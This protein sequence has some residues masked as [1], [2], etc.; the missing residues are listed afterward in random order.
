M[1]GMDWD[2]HGDEPGRW[3]CFSGAGS[4]EG[5]VAWVRVVWQ[6]VVRPREYRRIARPP[7]SFPSTCVK[8]DLGCEVNEHVQ[9]GKVGPDHAWDRHEFGD[10]GKRWRWPD[11]SLPLCS[12]PSL[13]NSTFQ[14]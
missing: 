7:V 9:G 13:L 11:A 5:G 4:C 6:M 1:A 2:G 10:G 8:F 3:R 12:C 14:T